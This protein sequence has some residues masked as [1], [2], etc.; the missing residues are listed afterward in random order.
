MSPK[1][2]DSATRMGVHLQQVGEPSLLGGGSNGSASANAAGNAVSSMRCRFVWS[3]LSRKPYGCELV[4]NTLLSS[5]VHAAC[6]SQMSYFWVHSGG[7]ASAGMNSSRDRCAPPGSN[8]NHNSY[9]SNDHGS[10]RSGQDSNIKRLQNSSSSSSKQQQQHGHNWH[11]SGSRLGVALLREEEGAEGG[12]MQGPTH[13]DHSSSNCAPG[14]DA[15]PQIGRKSSMQMQSRGGWTKEG[16]GLDLPSHISA[17]GEE[18]PEQQV[19]W[20]GDE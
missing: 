13:R 5:S 16:G 9:S 6:A 18:L 2:R 17:F 1:A 10:S 14:L 4:C 15:S 19:C 7:N 3:A 12:G 20:R 8:H 11:N